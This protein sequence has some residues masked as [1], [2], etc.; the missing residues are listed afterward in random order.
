MGRERE[1][2]AHSGYG[3][4]C[5]QCDGP[6]PMGVGYAAPGGYDKSVSRTSCDCGYSQL[7]EGAGRNG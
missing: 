1:A 3:Y 4:Q 6:A 2:D 5:K 7:P